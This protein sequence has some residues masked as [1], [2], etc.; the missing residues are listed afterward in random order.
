ML[1]DRTVQKLTTSMTLPQRSTNGFSP[2]SYKI[3]LCPPSYAAERLRV[4]LGSFPQSERAK[5]DPTVF[6]PA[7]AAM[8]A[9]FPQDIVQAVTDPVRGI[10]SEQ[11]WVPTL[12][13]LRHA[14]EVRLRPRQ[15][16]AKREAEL[17][18]TQ[19]MLAP[20]PPA[21][22]EQRERAV[23][24]WEAEK[25]ARARQARKYV[26]ERTAEEM[27]ETPLPA[28]SPHLVEATLAKMVRE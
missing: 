14:C 27:R 18:R 11:N 21:T 19:A 20:P 10:A 3:E 7:L 23:A 12:A 13:E 1:R 8:L 17:R 25:A 16:K 24:K 28:L 9:S 5:V 4:M 22:A 15:E 26:A 2:P 6:V